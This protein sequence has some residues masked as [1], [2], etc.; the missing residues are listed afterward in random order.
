MKTKA[1][2]GIFILAI[3][4][5]SCTPKD[6]FVVYSASSDE[7]S[8]NLYFVNVSTGESRQITNMEYANYPS[9]S[10]DGENVVFSSYEGLYSLDKSGRQLTKIVETPNFEIH[11]LWSPDGSKIAFISQHVEN[12]TLY[13]LM[14][15]NVDG[16]E[17]ITLASDLGE[18]DYFFS[19]SWSPDG[20]QLTFSKPVNES[21]EIFTIHAD[22]T[23]LT[24]ITN[25][26]MPSNVPSIQPAW[27]PDGKKI[28][29]VTWNLLIVNSD[30][31]NLVEWETVGRPQYPK[32]SPNGKY[33]ACRSYEN[34]I[35]VDP[36]DGQ[37]MTLGEGSS[38]ADYAW[39]SQGDELAYFVI[40]D[41]LNIEKFNVNSKQ[42]VQLTKDVGF[43]P[44]QTL[45]WQP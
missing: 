31:T 7:T 40:Q 1:L 33:I 42:K 41:T 22:G 9:W 12:N 3:L 36:T 43:Y 10:S 34:V 27:S 20:K 19:F 37:I 26:S 11:P 8:V 2:V 39:S 29:F 28:A 4:L 30:G 15:V 25:L 24:Q 44:W 35:L 6:H 18:I 14:V 38:I 5:V 23:G 13:D 45:A 32:W 17:L 16:T 21:R